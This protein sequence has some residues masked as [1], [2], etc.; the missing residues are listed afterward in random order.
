MLNHETRLRMQALAEAT[1]NAVLSAQ[2]I[3]RLS[4][5]Q[6]MRLVMFRALG[7]NDEV[8]ALT[9]A[10]AAAPYVHAVLAQSD[11]TVRHSYAAERSD[12]EIQQELLQIEQRLQLTLDAVPE[13]A[14]AAGA[15]AADHG[16]GDG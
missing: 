15:A 9:A 4:P 13:V 16:S 5:L 1:N 2:Q 10:K 14:P 7:R 8:G 6:V 3:E 12:V 11:V